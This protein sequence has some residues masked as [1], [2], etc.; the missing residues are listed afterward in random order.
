M[1]SSANNQTSLPTKPPPKCVMWPVPRSPSL[2]VHTPEG[3]QSDFR[4]QVR[5]RSVCQSSPELII[6][7][8]S[9]MSR[10]WLQI[11]QHKS[12][13]LLCVQQ[14]MTLMWWFYVELRL[15]RA[16]QS[17]INR[18]GLPHTLFVDFFKYI[19]DLVHIMC[20]SIHGNE[21]IITLP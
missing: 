13:S 10:L 2:R 11:K 16:P 1:G 12:L 4:T 7:I 19:P 8:S 6:L 5:L 20:S 18:A 14:Y 3:L 15:C 9:V 17:V 21:S